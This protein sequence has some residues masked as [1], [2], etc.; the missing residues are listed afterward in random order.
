VLRGQGQRPILLGV[1]DEALGI[2]CGIVRLSLKNHLGIE[3]KNW[4]ELKTFMGSA[5]ACRYYIHTHDYRVGENVE[6]HYTFCLKN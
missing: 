4:S 6:P 1:L 2:H 3:I 5:D